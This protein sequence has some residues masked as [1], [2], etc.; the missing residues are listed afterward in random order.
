MNR[1]KNKNFAR[2][3]SSCFFNS[4]KTFLDKGKVEFRN[5]FNFLGDF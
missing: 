1:K 2:K 3:G 5:T 4:Y